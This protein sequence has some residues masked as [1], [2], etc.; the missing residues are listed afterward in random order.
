L[1]VYTGPAAFYRYKIQ[2]EVVKNVIDR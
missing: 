2:V 1:R